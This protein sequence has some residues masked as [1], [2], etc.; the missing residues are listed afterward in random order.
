MLLTP[1]AA[2]AQDQETQDFVK[3][4]KDAYGEIPNQFAADTYDGIMVLAELMKKEKITNEM[5][6]SE[7]CEKLKKSHNRPRL[8]LQ[9][10]YRLKHEVE[11]GRRCIE[12]PESCNNQGRRLFGTLIL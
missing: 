9:R 10:T 8:L 5:E 2:D 4:Y 7:I 11:R 3:A 6:A 1:F 12:R